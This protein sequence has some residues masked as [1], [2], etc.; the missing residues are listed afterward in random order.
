[1]H[2]HFRKDS[3][4]LT[5]KGYTIFFSWEL[6]RISRHPLVSCYSEKVEGVGFRFDLPL[7]NPRYLCSSHRC[8]QSHHCVLATCSDH[9]YAGGR[10]SSSCIYSDTLIS[11]NRT[12]PNAQEP[13][14]PEFTLC[15][16]QIRAS[17]QVKIV[18]SLAIIIIGFLGCWLA[19]VIYFYHEFH[20]DHMQNRI[21][22]NIFKEMKEGGHEN[23]WVFQKLPWLWE[24]MEN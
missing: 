15:L 5:S 21:M 22:L 18:K 12:M 3:L 9:S 8:L 6:D 23:T 16:V 13:W 11:G 7:W 20:M 1:M 10:T 17:I 2:T 24:R 19:S 14:Q 4:F